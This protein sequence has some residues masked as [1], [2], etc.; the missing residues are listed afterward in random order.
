MEQYPLLRYQ[1]DNAKSNQPMAVN[2]NRED[3][4]LFY[5]L[6][7]KWKGKDYDY[8]IRDN[9]NNSLEFHNIK[10]YEFLERDVEKA[11][12]KGEILYELLTK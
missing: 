11:K 9:T 1:I 6:K 4:N 8:Q 10:P 12:N 7:G 3:A 5:N 2:K